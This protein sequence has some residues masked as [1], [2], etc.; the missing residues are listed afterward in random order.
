MLAS[1]P[2][3]M[4]A[5]T[6][7]ANQPSGSPLG[8]FPLVAIT[9]NRLGRLVGGFDVFVRHTTQVRAVGHPPLLLEVEAPVHPGRDRVRP[10]CSARDFIVFKPRCAEQNP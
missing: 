8:N 9:R 1:A 4:P 3:C 7:G 10:G 2:A 5:S 6:A